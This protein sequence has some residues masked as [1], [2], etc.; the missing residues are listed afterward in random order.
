MNVNA[1]TGFSP[2]YESNGT[3]IAGKAQYRIVA[4]K[5]NEPNVVSVSNIVLAKDRMGIYIPNAFTPN[6]DGVNDVFSVSGR[7]IDHFDMEIYNR[8]GAKIF[9]SEDPKKAWDGTYQGVVVPQGD[10]IYKV[11]AR[12]YDKKPFSQVGSVMVLY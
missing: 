9:E 10:Y 8:W 4:Y 11:F 12:G 7:S 6:G 5:T 1:Q 2:V 3:L